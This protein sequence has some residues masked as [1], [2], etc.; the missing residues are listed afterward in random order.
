MKLNITLSSL[1]FVALIQSSVMLLPPAAAASTKAVVRP[2]A[3]VGADTLTTDD[4]DSEISATLAEAQGRKLPSFDPDAVLKRL[5]QNRLLEQEGYRT[6]ADQ[7]TG[8]AQ[9]GAGLHS[10]E[11]R[12]SP[13]GFGFRAQGRNGL[14]ERGQPPRQGRHAQALFAHSRQGRAVGG[15]PP[16]QPLEGRRFRGSCQAALRGRDGGQGRRP[17]L[18]G[19]GGVCRRL[20]GGGLSTVL[21]RDLRPGPDPVRLARDH[22]DRDQGGYPQVQ[23]DGPSPGRG[24]GEGAAQG[25]R[26]A[27][28]SIR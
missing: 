4:L 1:L 14:G 15:R 6:G 16:G 17:G 27:D 23:G 26:G 25:R 12:A 13:A 20:R 5:I 24:A 9:P 2:L 7:A 10:P 8:R 28:T 3:V 11:E 19:G 18:G 22:P 21:E